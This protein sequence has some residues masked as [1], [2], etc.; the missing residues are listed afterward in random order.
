MPPP[1]SRRKVSSLKKR[2]GTPPR[3][4]F[5]DDA[6]PAPSAELFEEAHVVLEEE[7]DVVQF[8][9]QPAHAVDAEAE[10]EARE[11][12]GVNA[13]RAQDV[14][15]HHAGA[16]QLDP[17]GALA[18][19]AARAAALEAGVV[20]LHARLGEREVG[21]AEARPRLG[22]EEAADELG[23]RALQVSH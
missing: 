14:R 15:V 7:A 5:E 11:L 1:P 21:G 23:E 20:G 6:A 10:G 19:S 12:L 17:A 4:V 3:F 9:H 18:E 16:A 2:I 22:A 13:D 8:V